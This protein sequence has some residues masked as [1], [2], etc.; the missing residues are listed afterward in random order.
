MKLSKFFGMLFVASLAM[1][2]CSN[3]DITGDGPDINGGVSGEKTWAMLNFSIGEAVG[4]V[5]TV[6]VR[7]VASLPQLDLKRQ[8][9]HWICISLTRPANWN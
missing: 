5:L 6:S 7:M 9:N 2:S 4:T 3:D 8:W 1:A